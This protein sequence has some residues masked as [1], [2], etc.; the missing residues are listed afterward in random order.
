[1]IIIINI[2]SLTADRPPISLLINVCWFR[3]FW[4]RRRVATAR[5]RPCRRS[6]H[7]DGH[8]VMPTAMPKAT[9]TATATA[10][11]TVVYLSRSVANKENYWSRKSL[12]RRFPEQEQYWAG[13]YWS[14]KYVLGKLVIAKILV[15]QMLVRKITDQEM[16]IRNSTDRK[17]WYGKL[18]I[19]KILIRKITDR[20]NAGTENHWSGK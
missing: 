5:P 18:L 9:P 16:L 19:R 4:L 15:G 20:T 17:M 11:P 7:A 6:G 12:I 10:I 14:G 8:V 1:M 3:N 13:K 2:L